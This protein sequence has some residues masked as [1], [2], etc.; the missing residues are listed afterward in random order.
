MSKQLYLGVVLGLLTGCNPPCVEQVPGAVVVV[1]APKER[2]IY[3]W[4]A[5]DRVGPSAISVQGAHS[6]EVRV[7]L[8]LDP[9]ASQTRYTVQLD[10]QVD[11]LTIR[12][13]L[14]LASLSQRCGYEIAVHRPGQ[15]EAVSRRLGKVDSAFYLDESGFDYG[16][17]AQNYQ[18]LIRLSL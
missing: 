10:G 1:K 4:I 16:Y 18:I 14:A 6:D 9:T 15:G 12:Y 17:S 7:W 8:P 11:T 13:N 3:D 2:I 5:I